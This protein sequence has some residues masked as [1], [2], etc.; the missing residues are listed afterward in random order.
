MFLAGKEAGSRLVLSIVAVAVI[1]IATVLPY[2][3]GSR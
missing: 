2:G 3:D 1:G